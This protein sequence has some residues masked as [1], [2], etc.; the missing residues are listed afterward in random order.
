MKKNTLTGVMVLLVFAIFMVSILL[1]LLSGADTVQ[2]LTQRDQ[3]TYNHRTAVQY[4]STRVHQADRTGAIT[5]T[6]NDGTSL[7]VLTETIN[8]AEYETL[9]YCCDG[10]LREMFCQAGFDLPLEFGEE[11]LPMT[12]FQVHYQDALLTAEFYMTDGSS[13][14]I[15][16][17]LRSEGGNAA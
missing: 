3:R 10:Y 17:N 8:G 16:L 7:L 9:V 5:V 6:Q 14:T 11:I 1:I 2:R 13:E 4:L 12:D 15:C